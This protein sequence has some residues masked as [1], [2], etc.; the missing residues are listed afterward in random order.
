MLYICVHM[1]THTFGKNGYYYFNFSSHPHTVLCFLVCSHTYVGQMEISSW[2]TE[3]LVLFKKY[4]YFIILLCLYIYWYTFWKF[5]ASCHILVGYWSWYFLVEWL[6][7][8]FFL[9]E[10]CSLFCLAVKL[11]ASQCDTSCCREYKL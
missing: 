5:S 10:C 8:V 9:K 6:D 2:I 11:F 3:A 7:F 4:F 1:Y